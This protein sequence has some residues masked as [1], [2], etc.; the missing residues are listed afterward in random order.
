MYIDYQDL[1]FSFLKSHGEIGVLTS[2]LSAMQ[3]RKMP[4]LNKLL[5]KID[6]YDNFEQ[7]FKYK[8]L[9]ILNGVNEIWLYEHKNALENYIKSGR[10]LIN[11]ATNFT[12]YLPSQTSATSQAICRLERA[13]SSLANTQFFTALARMI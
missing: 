10:I 13:K 5:H 9:I 2:T 7:I 12:R 8:V 4:Y 1:D 6:I 11:F 3:E